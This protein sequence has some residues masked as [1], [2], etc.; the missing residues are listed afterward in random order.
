MLVRFKS[1][2]GGFTMF[3]D[4]AVELLRMAGHSGTVPGAIPAAEVPRALS[5]LEAAL[6]ARPEP[7]QANPA[8][9]ADDDGAA[10]EP[11][12]SLHQRAY[13]MLEMLRAAAK[14]E[15]GVM[16]DEP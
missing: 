7:D 8:D 12:V 3:G 6:A 10:G 5:R 2:V 14:D 13:P 16:W 11:P 1:D 15:C 9:E 4:V